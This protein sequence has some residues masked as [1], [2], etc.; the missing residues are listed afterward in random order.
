M[1]SFARRM[2][3]QQVGDD[4][5][6]FSTKRGTIMLM[7]N[8]AMSYLASLLSATAGDIQFE[9]GEMMSEEVLEEMLNKT[10]K[11]GIEMGKE[12]AHQKIMDA[13]AEAF[14]GGSQFSPEELR[15]LAV[16]ILQ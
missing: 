10:H 13:A 6:D 5:E 16:S 14:R 1:N 9:D 8:M 15:R 12:Q 3:K 2:W 11:S 7:N 4:G